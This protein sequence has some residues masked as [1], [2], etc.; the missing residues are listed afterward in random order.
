M[1]RFALIRADSFAHGCSQHFGF[2]PADWVSLA[3]LQTIR[4]DPKGGICIQGVEDTECPS[5]ES[6]MGCLQVLH[7]AGLAELNLRPLWTD[8]ATDMPLRLSRTHAALLWCVCSSLITAAVCRQ[9]VR[10]SATVAARLAPAH[11]CCDVDE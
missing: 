2:G 4:E 6:L 3:L 8:L 9:L 1:Q 5:F 7:S 11:D 10:V